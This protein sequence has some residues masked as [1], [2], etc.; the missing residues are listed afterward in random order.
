M[1]KSPEQYQVRHLHFFP[2]VGIPPTPTS[3]CLI[4]FNLQNPVISSIFCFYPFLDLCGRIRNIQFW[5]RLTTSFFCFFSS[6]FS[7]YYSPS[8]RSANIFSFYFIFSFFFYPFYVFFFVT[9]SFFLS[10]HSYLFIS[11]LKN[12]LYKKCSRLK[13]EPI[14]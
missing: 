14:T 10:R 3:V 8:F 5:F 2:E 13:R 12:S 11:L 4:L 7:H 6:T 1:I 9:F